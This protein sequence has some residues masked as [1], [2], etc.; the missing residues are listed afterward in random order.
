MIKEAKKL[1][2]EINNLRRERRD[3][4]TVDKKRKNTTAVKAKEK[5]RSD[6][7]KLVADIEK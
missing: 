5:K 6:I 3:N 1:V 4:I 2:V 7:L